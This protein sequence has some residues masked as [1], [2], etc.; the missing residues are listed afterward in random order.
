MKISQSTIDMSSSY[1]FEEE[2]QLQEQTTTKTSVSGRKTRLSGALQD[3]PTILMDRVSLFQSGTQQTTSGYSHLFSSGSQVTGADGQEISAFSQEQAVEKL[4][5]SIFGIQVSARILRDGDSIALGN[6]TGSGYSL[7]HPYSVTGVS[8][9]ALD[10][11]TSHF[12]QEQMTFSS[13]GQV[14]TEDGRTI[15]F[16]LNLAMDRSSLT[17][18]EEQTVI[19]SWQEQVALIDPLM[20]SLDGTV[21]QL[22]DI[23]FEF[24]LDNDGATEE[25]SFAAN[26]SGFLSFDKNSDGI[27]N[28]GSELFGPGTGNGFEELAAYD[29]DGNGWIDENDD[30]FSKLSAWTKDEDGNDVLTSLADAGVGAIY[31]D[32]AQTSFDLTGSDNQ[33]QGQVQRSG[34]F[35]FENGNVGMIQQIDLAAQPL[36][37]EGVSE[38]QSPAGMFQGTF[39]SGSTFVPESAGEQVSVQG[40]VADVKSSLD[41]LLE[42]IR[43]LQ[44]QL[45]K[46]LDL[47]DPSKKQPKRQ[48]SRLNFDFLNTGWMQNRI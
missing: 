1:I 18:T 47:D 2:Y 19:Q 12:E 21:P 48:R 15:D 7:S 32:S 37:T 17:T 16:S 5:S 4:V 14:T 46:I 34:A 33:L 45:R 39:T 8:T 20:I 24:D 29:M 31:L 40:G 9:M 36:E 41:E 13:M 42:Q 27:I 6:S 38:S 35:L 28:D 23:R 11:T 3:I 43:D 44:R 25:I 30:V 26:G 10:R 22:G